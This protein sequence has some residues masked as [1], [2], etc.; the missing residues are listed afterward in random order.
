M[1]TGSELALRDAAAHE[2]KAEAR[3]WMDKT[4]KDEPL[5]Q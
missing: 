2:P 3:E 5:G 4:P 1:S